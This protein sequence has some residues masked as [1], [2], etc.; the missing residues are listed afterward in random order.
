[1]ILDIALL[2]MS[3]IAITIGYN[4][5]ALATL[6]S[7]IGYLG[8][9]VVGFAAANWYTVDWK[10]F[11]SI[12]FLH[13]FGIFAGANLGKLIL[14]KSGLVIHARILFGPFKLL[15]SIVGSLIFFAQFVILIFAVLTIAL[16]L[17]FEVIQLVTEGSQVL[18][19][20]KVTF[21]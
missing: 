1:V 6:F 3:V 11:T 18:E 9:G 14:E 8:G 16:Q 2:V 7:L 4:R 19:K 5:G 10:D 13:L 12:I 15:N 21:T 20:I 17:P